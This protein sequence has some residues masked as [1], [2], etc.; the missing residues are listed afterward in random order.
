MPLTHPHLGH[1]LTATS[2][3]QPQ[4]QRDDYL[5]WRILVGSWLGAAPLAEISRVKVLEYH[6]LDAASVASHNNIVMATF[7]LAVRRMWDSG[8]FA[9]DAEARWLMFEARFPPP[10]A[11][12]VG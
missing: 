5:N 7:A 4:L 8:Q 3:D 6:H 10:H 12:A 11:V 2:A 1:G 9:R